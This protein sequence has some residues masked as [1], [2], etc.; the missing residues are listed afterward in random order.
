MS[1]SGKV[2][3]EVIRETELTN[4]EFL[5]LLSA[6]MKVTGTMSILSLG[7]I[8]FRISTENPSTARFL[9]KN[10]KEKLKLKVS[11][12]VKQASSLKKNNLYLISFD[13]VKD[14]KAF[15]IKT[16]VLE[17]E[18]GS[19]IFNHDVP[20]EFIKDENLKRS[21]IKG[22]F[23]ASGSVSD[24]EKQYHLEFVTHSEHYAGE[25]KKLLKTYGL[26]GKIVE[27][28]GNF[29][30]YIKEG[31]Q[32]SDM[33]GV[34][35]A[36]NSLLELENIRIIKDMR[37]NVNRIVNCETANLTKTV[38]AAVR[39]VESIK[40]IQKEYGLKRLPEQLREIAK[41]RLKHQDMP[42]VELGELLNPPIGKSGVNHRLRKIEKIAQE[43]E[44]GGI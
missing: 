2:K 18:D 17:I 8:G 32:I 15:L 9:Y 10:C 22:A 14:L 38:N 39:Q 7:K 3:A 5:A 36:H 29:V 23:L 43:L 13:A 16:Y 12:K 37:N 42:L 6:V 31:E 19:L 27:R 30:V 11:I 34:I 25:F 41:L 24:P 21:Y 20:E 33:L 26:K 28:Q 40:K 1:Y 4:E 44:N 35:G